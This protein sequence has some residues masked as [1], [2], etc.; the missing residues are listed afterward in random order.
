MVDTPTARNRL[1]KQ[2]LG[3]NVNTWGDDKLN[4]VIEAIDKS[5]DGVESFVLTGDKT[6]ITTNYTTA[7][8]SLNRVLKFTGTLAS[9]ANVIVPNVDHWYV[10]INAAGDQVTVKTN[11]G[12]GVAVPNGATALVYCD[13][14]DVLNAAPTVFS[15]GLSV[16][17]QI[18]GLSQG[19]A[20]TDAVNKVQMDTAIANQLTTGDGTIANSATDTTRR[21]LNTA[22]HFFGALTGAT[23]DSGADEWLDVKLRAAQ[24]V[25]IT[26]NM[27]LG[28][29]SI[30]FIDTTSAAITAL[31]LP[32]D[33]DGIDSADL[34]DGELVIIIDIGGSV[35]T[36]RVYRQ[37]QF[38]QRQTSRSNRR[39]H[40]RPQHKFRH[41]HKRL[42]QLSRS[43][44]GESTSVRKQL[45]LARL[46]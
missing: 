39:V 8:E 20:N 16:A 31:N 10:V 32:D 11:A 15:G 17:G 34:E 29:G 27:T 5:L 14:T 6:L 23:Q 36:K 21:F 18:N 25:A 44:V 3:T 45:W 1:R 2:E 38:Q 19:T 24:A 41:D 7:D 9:A 13:G 12:M 43:M 33:G 35:E 37:R 28:I 42:G 46:M 22:I 4:E 26:A 30:N 40:L